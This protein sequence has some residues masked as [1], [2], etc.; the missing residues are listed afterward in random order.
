MTAIE[1]MIYRI[2][3][4]R[5]ILINENTRVPWWILRRIEEAPSRIPSYHINVE[6]ESWQFDLR[7]PTR[8]SISKEITPPCSVTLSRSVLEK[9]YRGETTIRKSYN[10]GSIELGENLTLGVH[11]LQLL[12]MEL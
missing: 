8:L 2:T 5:L 7:D 10:E 11:L 3:C 9:I 4:E 6:S 12:E 1:Q